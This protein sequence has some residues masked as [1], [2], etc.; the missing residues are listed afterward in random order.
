MHRIGA[1]E[2]LFCFLDYDGTLAALAPTPDEAFPVPGTIELL[3]RLAAAPRTQVAIITGR[4][5]ENVRGLL[6]VPN[7]Y[8][9]GI[10][11]I[12]LRRPDGTSDLAG[13]LGLVWSFLPLLKHRLADELA[14]TQGILIEDKGVAVACHYRLA[15]Q[16]EAVRARQ[17]VSRIARMY[18]RR[19]LAI[20]V[21]D[22][23]A[24]TEIRPANV[25]KGTALASLLAMDAP[26]TTLA[27]FIGDDRTDAEAFAALPPDGIAIHVG[28]SPVPHRADFSVPDPYAVHQLL[29][30]VLEVRCP[31]RQSCG[32]VADG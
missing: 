9:V 29:K 18:Q 31:G 8:Y 23:H 2:H 27:L 6:D 12:E 24:V 19:G 14:D 32:G 30:R 21:L 22:G 15:T 1:A 17:A 7:A 4:T 28:P 11:G 5:I 3:T 20:D 25:T 13:G 16:S 10:H 26:T